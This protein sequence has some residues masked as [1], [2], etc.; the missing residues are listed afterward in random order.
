M[1]LLFKINELNNFADK[2]N[3]FNLFCN[4]YHIGLVH[5]KIATLILKHKLPYVLKNK[6]LFFKETKKKNLNITAKNTCELLVE[7]KIISQVTGENFPCVVSLG[8]KEL[9]TLERS[10]VEY[11]GIRG[12]GVHLIAYVR[13]GKSNIKVWIP[14]RAANKKVEPNKLDNTIAGGISAGETVYQALIREGFEEA[15]FKKKILNNAVQVGTINYIWRNKKFSLRRDTLFL[16]DL[17]LSN[18]ILPKNNDGEVSKFN[19]YSTAK[20]IEKIKNTNDFKKNC[21]LVLASFFIRRGLINSENEKDY[22]EI[23]R[24]L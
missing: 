24:L 22:E 5:K 17:E 21:A 9:F 12:F 23:C 6:N 15:S 7:K 8:K 19:L 10:L 14:L 11:L 20:I 3:F 18:K 13:T 4:N 16:F 2:E 1:S